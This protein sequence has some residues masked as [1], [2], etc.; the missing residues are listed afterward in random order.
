MKLLSILLDLLFIAALAGAWAASPDTLS[1]VENTLPAQLQKIHPG[2]MSRVE[3]RQVLGTPRESESKADF[4]DLAG[5]TYDTTIGYDGD[6]VR[7]VSFEP[8]QAK[9]PSLAEL[10]LTVSE[11]ERKRSIEAQPESHEKGRVFFVERRDLGLRLEV[12]NT[13][14]ALVRRVLLWEKGRSAP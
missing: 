6:R 8:K 1:R 14:D 11:T 13:R 5:K 7:Y 4:Y 9:R 10:G 2:K 3:A 12:D